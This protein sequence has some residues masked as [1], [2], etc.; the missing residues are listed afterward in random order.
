MRSDGTLEPIELSGPADLF[1]PDHGT[2]VEM[3]ALAK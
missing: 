3:E 2:I 1:G